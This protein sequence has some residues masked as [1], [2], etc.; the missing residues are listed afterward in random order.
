MWAII[1]QACVSVAVVGAAIAYIYK[2]I[3]FAKKPGDDINEKLQRDFDRINDLEDEK[4]EIRN[5]MTYLKECLKL[6]LEN[7]K[8][9]LEHM[10]T[11]N[12]SGDIGKREKATF[13]FL[14][15]HQP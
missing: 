14:N 13:D 9:M 8:V 4:R 3:R 15:A 2:A 1:Q 7:D 11:N 5:D 12:A 6:L 10:R